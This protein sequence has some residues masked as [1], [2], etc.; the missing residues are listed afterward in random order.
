LEERYKESQQVDVTK[1]ETF[2]KGK[3]IKAII[4]R[5]IAR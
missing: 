3:E 4:N 5:K 2:P 1:S